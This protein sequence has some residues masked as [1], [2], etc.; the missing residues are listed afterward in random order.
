[1][2][3]RELSG[4]VSGAIRRFSAFSHAYLRPAGN[5]RPMP[6]RS[7]ECFD[8][9]TLGDVARQAPL[10][11]RMELKF[12]LPM[13]DLEA[14]LA[15]LASSH[16]VLEIDGL[17][18][19]RYVTTYY[20]TPDRV[21]FREH[22][23]GRRRRFKLRWRRYVDT[24]GSQLEVK[25]KGRRGRTVKH[26]APYGGADQL[27]AEALSFVRETLQAT[28]GREP[29][30]PLLP[31]LTVECKRITLVEPTRR[32]RLTCDTEVSLGDARLASGYAIVE[33]KSHDGRAAAHAPLRTLSAR[34]LACCSKYCLGI[35]FADPEQSSG[36][37]R[38]VMRRFFE[39]TPGLLSPVEA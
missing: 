10:H 6:D 32:E 36:D 17:R 31:T 24:G 16:R 5:K 26:S 7:V 35:A 33:T 3:M 23:S 29:P 9:I 15:R 38:P 22:R 21:C 13:A 28:Y 1:M 19:F 25:L 14:L 2:K 4:E 18:V 11:E 8:P 30:R 12:I 37:L 39:P 27:G 20:D 34:P